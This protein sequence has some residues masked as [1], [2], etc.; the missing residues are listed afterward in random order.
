MAVEL[1]ELGNQDV[2]VDMPDYDRAEELQARFNAEAAEWEGK[3]KAVM[4]EVH[5]VF[6]RGG[7]WKDKETENLMYDRCYGVQKW[8][9]E[10]AELRK[11]GCVGDTEVTEVKV[12]CDAGH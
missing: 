1:Q 9:D 11:V 6:I 5:E 12:E 2:D 4:S 8:L 7:K 3:A 10:L